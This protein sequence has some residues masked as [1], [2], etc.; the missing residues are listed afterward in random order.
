MK[1]SEKF[2]KDGKKAHSPPQ[3]HALFRPSGRYISIPVGI[4]VHRSAHIY[5]AR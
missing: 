4:Y 2:T 5:P 1:N 3:N